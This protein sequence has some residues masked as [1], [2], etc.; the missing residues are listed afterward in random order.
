MIGVAFDNASV[1][2]GSVEGLEVQLKND[3]ARLFVLGC[4]SHSTA[5]CA[6]YAMK[7]LLDGLEFFSGT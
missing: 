4:T 2:T 1:N 5:Q 6:G 3:I 7:F